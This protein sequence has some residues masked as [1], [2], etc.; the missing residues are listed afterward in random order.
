VAKDGSV[1]AWGKNNL[2][3]CGRGNKVLT[4][5]ERKALHDQGVEPAVVEGLPRIRQVALGNNHTVCLSE[6]GE[7][8]V[9]GAAR[10]GQLGIPA[11][12]NSVAS[13]QKLEGL[14]K[15]SEVS[16][17][18]S[19]TVAVSE[20]GEV[21]SW[22]DDA[23]GQLG[24]GR[25]QLVS[26]TPKQ[27][28]SIRNVATLCAGFEHVVAVT[29]DG[30]VY[31]WGYG[32]DGQLGHNNLSDIQKPKHVEALK[33]KKSVACAAGGGHSAVVTDKGAVFVFGKGRDGQLGRAD[34]LES[35]AAHRP[36]PIEVEALRGQKVKKVALGGDY[37][38]AI[39]S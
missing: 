8:F 34:Q 1:Y 11:P 29:K 15:I 28:Q 24:L 20:G 16:C 27:V 5:K 14:P 37:T 4:S 7:L 33:G 35:I 25:S 21:F 32:R 39:T 18:R 13:P 31:T 9:F 23:Y 38:I 36:E 26:E 30:E 22:G 17:G 12:G 6:E 19:F 3:Q 10:D 2:M